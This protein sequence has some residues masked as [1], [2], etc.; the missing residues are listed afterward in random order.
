MPE[1]KK[2][3][4]LYGL[5]RVNI[6]GYQHY[7]NKY[8]KRAKIYCMCSSY[9]GFPMVLLEAMGYGVVPIA[10]NTFEAYN[11]IID[12]G[13]CGF[14]IK[15]YDEDAYVSQL[16]SLMEN[17]ASLKVLQES[18]IERSVDFLPEV[19]FSQWDNLFTELI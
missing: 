14:S 7:V 12:N 4:E 18:C 17:E 2:L 13:N 19:I 3:I 9:E 10:F 16:I 8:Y 11:S 1:V 15:P 5:K 6:E